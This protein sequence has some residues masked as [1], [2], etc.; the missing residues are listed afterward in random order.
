MKWLLGLVRKIIRLYTNG[1]CYNYTMPSNF[2]DLRIVDFCQLNCKH[3]YLK[4]GKRVMPLDM[5]RT[6]CEGF[7]STNFPLPRSELILSGGEPLLHPKYVEKRAEK[8]GD[9]FA[10]RLHRRRVHR[11]D[12]GWHRC[13]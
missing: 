5:L 4:K 11:S 6:I 7:L 2:L 12:I 8:E 9:I 13:F 10:K 1:E 3:C